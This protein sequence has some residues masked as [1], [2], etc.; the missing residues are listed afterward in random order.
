MVELNASFAYRH[1]GKKTN[2]SDDVLIIYRKCREGCK[3]IY[4]L[5]EEYGTTYKYMHCI[6]SGRKRRT[7]CDLYLVEPPLIS[8]PEE[9]LDVFYV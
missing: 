1:L 4:K 2:I 3:D 5:A 7:V 6:L 9:K 8:K